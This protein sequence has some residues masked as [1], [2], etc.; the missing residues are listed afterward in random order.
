MGAGFTG[1][2]QDCLHFDSLAWARNVSHPPFPNSPRP[3]C[4]PTTAWAQGP[5]ALSS[6]PC[7]PSPALALLTETVSHCSFHVSRR[8][9]VLFPGGSSLVPS[10]WC[11]CEL[12]KCKDELV[13]SQL[14]TP[15]CLPGAQRTKSRPSSTF[16][17]V[18][19]LSLS[20]TLSPRLISSPKRSSCTTP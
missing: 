13:S 8:H 14:H 17:D 6:C 20:V 2:S 10:C 19:A 7:G 4:P 5:C 15:S 3:R 11:P 18:H 16:H 1:P 9:I 12:V